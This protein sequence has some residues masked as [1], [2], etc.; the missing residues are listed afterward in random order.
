M[1]NADCNHEAPW[2]H[3]FITLLDVHSSNLENSVRMIYSRA[4]P[5]FNMQKIFLAGYLL[6]VLLENILEGAKSTLCVPTTTVMAFSMD[7]RIPYWNKMRPSVDCVT[8]TS[9]HAK[10]VEN[11]V[12]EVIQ[13]KV[14]HQNKKN[15][16]LKSRKDVF[17]DVF[18]LS[19]STMVA[20]S[21]L[22][23]TL[24]PQ[25][26]YATSIDPKTGISLPDIGE[27][28]NSIPQDWDGMD[29]P[30]LEDKGTAFS[31]LDTSP[32]SIFYEAPRFVEHVDDNA[33]NILTN[34][35]SD[36][37][38][39]GSS[40]SGNVESILDICSSWTSHISPQALSTNGNVK[41]ISGLGMNLKELEANTILTD[42][43]LCGN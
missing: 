1:G 38:I 35:I 19:F 29:N 28:E 22:P 39:N 33:V 11:D 7:N 12:V 20:T 37:V 9:K 34:Y 27:I 26:A 42:A 4:T 41:R 18:K 36:D 43:G 10:I 8:M 5:K 15:M 23:T 13:E 2:I 16:F 30:L 25:V 3:Y 14:L 32:D 6:L 40:G 31:R 24:L 21:F 17:Q